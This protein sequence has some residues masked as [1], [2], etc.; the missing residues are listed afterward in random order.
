MK[1]VVNAG[2][3][4]HSFVID[5]DAY[6]RLETYLAHFR[7]RLQGGEDEVME[8]LENRISELFLAEINQPSQVVTL[9]MVQRIIAQ[10]GMPDGSYET[11]S[12]DADHS[13]DTPAPK[14]FYRDPDGKNIAGV[15]SGIALYF[16]I[17]VVLVRIL[18]LVLLF[19]GT[20]GFWIYLIVW[21]VAPLADT[22]AKKCE[23]RGIPATAENM[24]KFNVKKQ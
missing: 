12:G 4:G 13:S 3:G 19:A 1:K 10:L 23:M 6:Q 14:K 24:S 2:I 8:D 21:I 22:P 20:G 17:D 5:E 15:C 9:D 18:F 7:A 16:D 11:A